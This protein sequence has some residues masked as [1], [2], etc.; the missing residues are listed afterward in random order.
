MRTASFCLA[1][2]LAVAGLLPAAAPAG[3]PNFPARG[4]EGGNRVPAWQIAL[5]PA[6]AG[7][8]RFRLSSPRGVV[9]AEGT[10]K[11]AA[12]VIVLPAFG[13]LKGEYGL[14]GPVTIGQRSRPM[15][16]LIGPSRKGAPCEDSNG[17]KYGQAVF[18]AI[19][20]E[21]DPDTLYYGCG[22]YTQP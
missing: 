17:K 15:Q 6:E 10:L 14:A 9:I 12:P 3:A 19:G 13:E 22:E 1:A 18:I 2:L 16:V 7:L 11:S 5:K 20:D 4:F 8:V 21:R